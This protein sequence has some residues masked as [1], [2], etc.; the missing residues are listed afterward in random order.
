[1]QP[2][3]KQMPYHIN[4]EGDANRHKL[5]EKS[6]VLSCSAAKNYAFANEEVFSS[7]FFCLGDIT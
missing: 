3:P 6:T 5:S 1:M 7:L 2:F 4:S